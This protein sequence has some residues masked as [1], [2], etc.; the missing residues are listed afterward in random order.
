MEDPMEER[1]SLFGIEP[2]VKRTYTKSG[3]YSKTAAKPKRKRRKGLHYRRG[4]ENTT[5][6]WLAGYAVVHDQIIMDVKR[7]VAMFDTG[8]LSIYILSGY[9][10]R[11]NE[12]HP[13]PSPSGHSAV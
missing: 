2:E 9:T 3:K 6:F 13:I 5:F 8:N 7:G 10:N 4:K 11:P 1:S 12:P